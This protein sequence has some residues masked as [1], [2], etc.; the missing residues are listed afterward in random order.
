VTVPFDLDRFVAAQDPVYA[1]VRAELAAGAKTSHWMW[2]VFPQL[3]GLGRSAT[4]EH[5]GIE[6]RAE[7]E[8]YL[9]HPVLGERL[10][11]CTR[12]ALAVRG[13]DA[14][15]IFGTPDDMKFHSSMTLFAEVTDDPLFAE[16][17][18][19]Y[20]SGLRDGRTLQLLKER[21]GPSS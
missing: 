16:A 4:A 12:L 21:A 20:F 5:F 6:N 14:T 9:R 3:R 1:R 7:A 15:G 13:R 11:E 8:A 10:R 17:L 18:A 2:F 19:R